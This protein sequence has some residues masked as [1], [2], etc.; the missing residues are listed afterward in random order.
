MYIPLEEYLYILKINR[1][2]ESFIRKK[3]LGASTGS[4]KLPEIRSEG[5][6]V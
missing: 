4:R 5:G 3:I 2:D 6:K 1:F